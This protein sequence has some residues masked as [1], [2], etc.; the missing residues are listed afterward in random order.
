MVYSVGT[1]SFEKQHKAGGRIKKEFPDS[2][3]EM[4]L[5]CG[6]FLLGLSTWDGLT[7]TG[8]QGH[9]GMLMV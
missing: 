7:R 8:T 1:R 6:W 3:W 4:P 9:R 2:I 5:G